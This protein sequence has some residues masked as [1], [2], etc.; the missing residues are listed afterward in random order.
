MDLVKEDMLLKIR[1]E[2][3]RCA[4]NEVWHAQK[5]DHMPDSNCKCSIRSH[6]NYPKCFTSPDCSRLCCIELNPRAL[7]R[8]LRGGNAIHLNNACMASIL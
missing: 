2:V 5:Q 4:V 6:M 7:L 8:S 3:S 1:N